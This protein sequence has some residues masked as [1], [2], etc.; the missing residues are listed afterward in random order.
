[1]LD[2]NPDGAVVECDGE[3]CVAVADAEAA[4]GVAGE[5]GLAVV[6]VGHGPCAQFVEGA[7]G[8]PCE[9]VEEQD[10]CLGA[11]VLAEGVAEAEGLLASPFG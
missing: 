8:L 6:V 3:G 5:E 7:P 1:M 2:I 4:V 9:E 10:P 11:G